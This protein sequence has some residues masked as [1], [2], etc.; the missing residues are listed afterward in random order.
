MRNY[1][2]EG[3]VITA[4]APYALTSG[5][6]VLVGAALFGVAAHDA[7]NG[8]EVAIATSGVYDITALSTDTAAV[9]AKLFWDNTN[10]RLTTTASTHICA[11]FAVAAKASGDT[12]ARIKLVLGYDK[13]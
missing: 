12:T 2:S 9:G 11:G 8:A 13:A 6:G 4:A 1:V 5:Q 3:E 7:A 10:R